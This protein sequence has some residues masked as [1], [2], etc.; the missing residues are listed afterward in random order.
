M[1]II[2]AA[3][4]G[5]GLSTVGNQMMN[6]GATSML[7]Q[8]RDEAE[9]NKLKM[10][11]EFS[12]QN[13]QTSADL[14]VQ[15]HQKNAAFDSSDDQISAAAK[16]E[17]MLE[18]TRIDTQTAAGNDPAY[19]K[20]LKNIKRAT[21]IDHDAALRNVQM[22][23]AQLALDRAREEQKIPVSV[24]KSF[25]AAKSNYHDLLTI[26]SKDGFDPT[27][28]TGQQILAEQQA[29]S[30]RMSDLMAPY[31]PDDLR[32]PPPPPKTATADQIAAYAKTKGQSVDAVTAALKASGYTIIQATPP[33]APAANDVKAVPAAQTPPGP[34]QVIG[35]IQNFGPGK[36][37]TTP[38][39]GVTGY[40]IPAVPR[41]SAAQNLTI[42]EARSLGYVR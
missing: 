33:S 23:A 38:R 9:Q 27:S 17:G 42:E 32:A 11:Q 34:S 1:G 2:S 16:K 7:Q 41:K 18:Q 39:S 25:D 5:A 19:L 4:I 37:V 29:A 14:A 21:D 30:K 3:G 13:M 10:A 12:Q 31:L 24:A 26:S 8:Q 22:Q 36:L 40:Y 15:T 35:D 28:T 20:S 6:L